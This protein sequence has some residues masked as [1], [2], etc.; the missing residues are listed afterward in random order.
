MLKADLHVHSHHSRDSESTGEE[1]VEAALRRN[2]DAVAVTDHD[3][4]AGSRETMEAARD[5]DSDL[6]VVP[7]QEVST[8]S[9]HL[10]VLGVDEQAP[11][12][13]LR[14][15]ARWTHDRGG[16]CVA[17]HPFQ[18]YRHGVGK[19]VLR[20]PEPVDG[21]EVCNSRYIVSIGNWRAERL[22][23][24]YGYPKLGGSDAHIPEMVG[25]VY[26]LIDAEPTV[27]GVLDGIRGG[28]TR[29]KKGKTPAALF[30]KQLVGTVKG[31]ITG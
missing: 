11:G 1:I 28:R 19:A 16:I 4:Y 18:R 3:S 13:S 10:L 20:T 2:L 21:V 29:V 5:L 12:G 15:T 9:G 26:T 7:G 14:D 22:A 30:L 25:R 23:D 31:R 17:P 6:L 27:Q 8:G 24:R